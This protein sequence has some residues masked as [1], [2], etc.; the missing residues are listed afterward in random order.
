[1]EVPKEHLLCG[2]F[3]V[4]LKEDKSNLQSQ[5]DN[6]QFSGVRRQGLTR[7]STKEPSRRTEIP[8]F[9]ALM[10]VESGL[11]SCP[12][13]ST[14]TLKSGRA[15]VCKLYLKKVDFLNAF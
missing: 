3:S 13:S 4:K 9:S 6:Q 14:F 15:T 12:H 2:S 1:M 7:K 11:Y 5:K 10:K 8:I